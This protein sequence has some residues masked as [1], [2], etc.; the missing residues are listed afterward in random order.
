MI[1]TSARR[2]ADIVKQVLTF[3]RGTEGERTLLQPK[4]IL[5]E[6]EKITRETF[7]RTIDIRT[8]LPANLWAITGDATQLH[9]I[10]LNLLVN[11]R[12]AMPEGGRLTLKAENVELDE[13]GTQMHLNAKPGSYVALSIRDTGSGIPQDILDKIFDPFFTTKEVGKGTGL[14]LSTVMAIVKSYGGFII[15]ESVVGKGTEIRVFIPATNADFVPRPE[16]TRNQLPAGR[17][18]SI[19]VVDDELSIREITKE[20]LEAYGYRIR[21]A[22]DGIEALSLIEKDRHKFSLVLTDM[23]MPN[24]DGS[25]LIRTLERLAP[26]IKIIAVSGITDQDIFEKLKKSRVEA[27]LP[28]PI[29]TDNLL[30]ILDSVLHP[31]GSAAPSPN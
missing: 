3:A 1:E 8:E 23:M 2:G 22:K 18:E 4:H 30:K 11:A 14:G 27:F 17:G 15:V 29:Q 20:T 31:D 10:V 21:T 19:L 9:Q 26:D 5:R 28:K 24:M 16:D 12:D 13:Q 25:S 6:V 7:P